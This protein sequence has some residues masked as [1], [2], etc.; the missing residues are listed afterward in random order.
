MMGAYSMVFFYFYP[1]AFGGHK[2]QKVKK[3][4]AVGI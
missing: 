2:R 4:N 1:A 3:N